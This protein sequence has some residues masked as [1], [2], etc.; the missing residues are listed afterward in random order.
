MIMKTRFTIIAIA[1]MTALACEKSTDNLNLV[2]QSKFYIEESELNDV[3]LML[4][5]IGLDDDL[6]NEVH[7]SVSVAIEKGLDED[8]YFRELWMKDEDVKVKSYNSGSILKDRLEDYF[9]KNPSTKN[10]E[11]N[12]LKDS[13]IE[14]YW[15]YSENWDGKTKPVIA[16]VP[17]GQECDTLY[18]YK[19]ISEP[20]SKVK[21]D[22]VLVD[23]DYAYENPVWI[24]NHMEFPYEYI[25][26]SYLDD[27][28]VKSSEDTF[29][30][31]MYKAK[32][33]K[34]YDK[35]SN[36]DSEFYFIIAT[37]PA[38]AG[39]VNTPS[40]RPFSFSRKQI[41]KEEEVVINLPL[42]LSWSSNQLSNHMI[43]VELN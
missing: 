40:R 11:G 12:F 28:N 42:N 17:V 23:D 18:G 41:R 29:G 24:I 19:V 37:P 25:C 30:W 8:L 7:S 3:A 2:E 4:T 16:P 26:D 1:F 20:G 21:L 43:F 15:P 35:L 13:N 10:T 39:V 6:C 14:I 9:M 38:S 34:Q 31:Y 22:T 5:E 32:C 36:G 27:F 33:T